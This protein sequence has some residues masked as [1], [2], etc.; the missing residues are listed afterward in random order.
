MLAGFFEQFLDR[1]EQRGFVQVL[2]RS[3]ETKRVHK[4]ELRLNPIDTEH[5]LQQGA[6][7]GG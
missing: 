5:E 1:R 3:A 7:L 2:L 6:P 4:H